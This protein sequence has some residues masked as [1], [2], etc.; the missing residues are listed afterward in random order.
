MRS[1]PTSMLSQ[2]GNEIGVAFRVR[3]PGSHAT[4]FKLT[5]RMCLGRSWVLES[6]GLVTRML[7][8][9]GPSALAASAQLASLALSTAMDGDVAGVGR[10]TTAVQARRHR[11]WPNLQ[12]CGLTRNISVAQAF[13]SNLSGSV[14]G[15]RRQGN[16]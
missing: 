2:S 16:S 7:A 1:F 13:R 12:E 5:R 14:Y 9:G 15:D 6:P 8:A 3:A 10:G 11:L 4:G